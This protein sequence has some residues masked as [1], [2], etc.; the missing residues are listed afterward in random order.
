V[1]YAFH[2]VMS[3]LALMVMAL[4]GVTIG[5]TDGANSTFRKTGWRGH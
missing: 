3:G 4:L 1:L 5:N 2:I